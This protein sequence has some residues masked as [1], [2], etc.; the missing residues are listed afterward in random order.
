MS[1]F[2]S[3]Y[4]GY[5]DNRNKRDPEYEEY[6]PHATGNR[7][8]IADFNKILE[9]DR[10]N[11]YRGSI[12]QGDFKHFVD[13]V[14]SIEEVS[15]VQRRALEH[16]YVKLFWALNEYDKSGRG[17]HDNYAKVGV[18]QNDNKDKKNQYGHWTRGVRTLG[19]TDPFKQM[20]RPSTHRPGENEKLLEETKPQ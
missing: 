14:K 1:E 4:P 19:Y 12:K 20:S 9:E 16:D 17:M 8:M 13:H 7:R 15:P 2:P 3:R 6:D 10:D 18:I 5:F 11:K